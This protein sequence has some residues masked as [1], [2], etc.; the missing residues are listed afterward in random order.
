MYIMF[1]C[2]EHI[3]DLYATSEH[4]KYVGNQ[5]ICDYIIGMNEV[6]GLEDELVWR[7]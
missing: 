5:R 1:N 3:I 7:V 4:C 2:L 6:L